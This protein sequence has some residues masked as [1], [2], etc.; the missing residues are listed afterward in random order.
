MKSLHHGQIVSNRRT[1]VFLAEEMDTSVTY[2]SVYL[3]SHGLDSQESYLRLFVTCSRLY[4]LSRIVYRGSDGVFKKLDEKEYKRILF[5]GHA[6][7]SNEILSIM[8]NQNAE[9]NA[10]MT[11]AEK[12]FGDLRILESLWCRA[13]ACVEEQIYIPE[14]AYELDYV[15]KNSGW[16]SKPEYSSEYSLFPNNYEN[17]NYTE[18]I[19]DYFENIM[20]TI[21]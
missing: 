19:A 4:Y 5:E 12:V 7:N 6:E 16:L 18:G 20:G 14:L 10:S 8:V 13:I 3:L 15:F 17:F 9:K 21:F 1:I 2:N 11:M